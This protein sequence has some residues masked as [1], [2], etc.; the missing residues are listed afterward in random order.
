MQYFMQ[1]RF[2]FLIVTLLT[3][4]LTALAQVTTSSM[5]GKVTFDDQ[6]GEE[7]IG[8]T[9]IAVH[10]P[11]GTRYTAVTN[12]SGRFTIQGMRTGGPYDLN[13]SYV[14][15][16]TKTVKGIIL[17]LGETYNQNV[18]LSANATEL[19]EIVVSG[20]ATKFTAEKTGA[21]TSISNS[22]IASMP[23]INRSISDVA[24][25]SPYA[26]GMS[27]AGGDGRSTNFTI[28]GANFNNNFGLSDK[29]PGGGNPIS[30]DAI[31]EVQVVIAPFDVRQTNF[32]GGGIN[33]ITKSGTNTFKGTAYTYYRDQ[34]LRGNRIDHMDLG[35]RPDEKKTIYGFTL[36]GPIIKD[37]LFFF[38][39]YEGEKTP[40]QAVKYRAADDLNGEVGGSGLVSRTKVSDL[41]RVSDFAASAYGYSTGSYTDFPA[42]ESNNRFLARLDWNITDA[43]HLAVRFNSTKNVTWLGPNGNSSDTGYRLNGT[44]RVGIQSMSYANSMYSM[45]NKVQSISADLNSRFGEKISNQLLFTYTNISDM[46]GTNSSAFPF[47]D[48]MAGKDANGN[49]L[50]E[51]YIS[52]GYELFT[53]NNGVKNKITNITDNFTL[54]LAN[55]KITAGISF[56]HQMASNAYMRNGTGYYRFNSIDD[57]LN[58]A[59]PESFA[60]TYGFNGVGEPSAEVKFNQLGFYAQDEWNITDKFKLTYGVRFDNLSYNSDDLQRNNTI[61][62]MTFRDGQK[63]DTG[64]WPNSRIQISPR[65]GFTYDVFGD[66]VLKVRGGTGIFTGRLP[67]VFL[68]N[69]PTNAN[70][71]QNSV[72]YTTSYKNGVPT[73]SY[74][75]NLEKFAGGIITNV[76]D[77]I[78]KLNLPTT[79]ENHV[80]GRKISG[81]DSD[82]RMPQIWKSSVAVDYQ[83]PVSF[84]FT[85]TAEFMFNKNINAVI[86]DNINIQDPNENGWERFNGSDDR[87]IYP[88]DYSVTGSTKTNSVMLKNTSKGYGYTFNLTLNATPVE[89]LNLMAAY[90]HT[91]QKEV[92]GLPGSDPISTWQNLSTVDG[93]N[94]TTPQ[95]SRYVIPDKIIASVGYFIPFKHKNLTR[96]THVN[97]FYSGYSDSGYDFCYT[98][99]M[100]GD[101]ISNDLMY[102]PANDNE[103]QIGSLNNGQFVNNP[104]MRAAFWNFVDQDSY[105]KNHKG[106][107]AEAYA[108]RSPWVH[109][110]DL[111]IAE[112]FCFKIGKTDHKF[113]VSLD[114]LN[115]GNLINSSWGVSSISTTT[116]NQNYNRFLKYEGMDSNKKPVFSMVKVNGEYPKETYESYRNYSDCWKLQ[117]GVKYFFN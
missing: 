49:Q 56:E 105:L 109:R 38:V 6:S 117:V 110:F 33:A 77:M 72:T 100:N 62:D 4:S 115:V 18:G 50:M 16:Q 7:V 23:T 82:F 98:N 89:N 2:L 91:E 20:R 80:A 73:G 12:T 44:Y 101:G 51:P 102:I 90:T 36:G 46:R 42:D 24:K 97:L 29:L 69:M 65:L 31:E 113:Q 112:D 104:E 8:A 53:F 96:G 63:I 107:Y 58:K 78:T 52:L 17:Q 71:I 114:F 59:R 14:G 60:L 34:S 57:F 30:I 28:D 37:K 61:Y 39:N 66:K 67:L 22:Q 27:F 41:Q 35:A 103:I 21:S 93:S 11:S 43:H 40:G 88:K 79:I 25:I 85:A 32:I 1:K 81:V 108:A 15:Y 76:N 99:D 3:V 116:G 48:I 13:V 92:S 87:L 106:E 70:M 47:I 55:H 74:D 10:T 26:S 83:I 94:F 75:Q 95:R 54:Y 9:V 19:T 86:I 68:T 64:T 111:R 5:T 45:E 84:P